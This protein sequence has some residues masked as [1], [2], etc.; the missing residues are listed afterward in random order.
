MFAVKRLLARAVLNAEVGVTAIPTL[1]FVTASV[2]ST[3]KRKGRDH[4]NSVAGLNLHAT[5]APPRFA[6]SLDSSHHSGTNVVEAEVD[7]LVRSFVLIMT[8]ATTITSMVDPVLVAKE[9]LVEPSLFCAESSSASGTGPTTSVFL[10]LTSSDF[11]VGDI[12]AMVDEFASPK[13]F[14]SVRGMEHDLLFTEFNVGAARQMS[15]SAEVRMRVEYNFKE[16]RRLKSVVER[17]GELLK[18]IRLCAEASNFK[19][20]EKSL[21]YEMNAL[22]ERNAVLEKEQNALD[23][24]VTDHEASDVG[25]EH[26]LTDLNALI[27]SVKSQN[28]NLVDQVHELET[29]SFGHQEKLY[30]DFMEMAL[31]LEEKFYPHLLTIVFDR[32]WLLT[33][34][35]KLAIIKCL[36]SPEYLSALGAT[37]GKDIEKGIQ[38]GLS[39]GITHG[40]EGWV[41]TDVDA[42]N[43]SVD[44]D[45]L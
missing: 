13:F 28:D 30:T 35:M 22:K 32:R 19:A 43:P 39:A 20:V 36:N 42:H 3:S 18:A 26:D 16:K 7:S 9:K 27:T 10:D 23:V 17:Q 25:K 2:S 38:D 33:Q 40:K 12:R 14:A 34:G 8:T 37:I 5:R 44:V 24:K 41:L 29:S 6:I 21:R 1:P 11:L 45:Y 4:T 31:H 15:L